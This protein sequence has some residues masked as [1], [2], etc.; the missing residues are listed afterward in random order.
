VNIYRKIMVLS[1]I[2]LFIGAGVIPSI[3]SNES[4]FG[5][6]S[7]GDTLYVGG[8][9]PSNYTTIQSA[10]D[11]A[12]SGDT[13]FVYAGTYYENV[14]IEKTINLIGN[15]RSTTIIDGGGI[16]DVIDI[17]VGF[18][19]IKEFSILNSG[20]Y[21]HRG[22]FLD[23]VQQC[24]IENNT[25]TNNFEGIWLNYSSVNI[26]KGNTISNNDDSGIW[27]FHSSDN[28]IEGNAIKYNLWDGVVIWGSLDNTI[29]GNT[30]SNNGQEGIDIAM[31]SN[32]NSIEG[33]T[34]SNNEDDGIWLYNSLYNKIEGNTICNNEDDGIELGF[35]LYDITSNNNVEGNT[36]SDNKDDGIELGDKSINNDIIG[37]TIRNNHHNG[38]MIETSCNNNKVYQNN[39]INNEINAIDEGR[40]EWDDGEL[41]N[42]WEDYEDKY[43][44]AKKQRLTGIWNTAY[45]IP[46]GD[47][48]DQYPL[49]NQFEKTKVL[50]TPLIEILKIQ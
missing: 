35:Y 17:S 40:N 30:I 19:I 33:N 2:G 4:T 5:M 16:G 6:M 47:N 44:N 24:R 41:G 39:F 20:R 29:N 49:I 12:S 43:P 38:I 31:S 27:L 34:I 7:S 45:D 50:Q 11:A 9:G 26:L 21:P 25:I 3:S 42:Y 23:N 1:I 13:V 10:I 36:I 46:T 14:A 32:Y 15:D 37:N 22:I 48:Q 28:I 8:T 18:V